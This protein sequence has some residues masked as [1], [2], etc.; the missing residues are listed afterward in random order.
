LRYAGDFYVPDINMLI[1]G[2]ITAL[3]V[4]ELFLAGK[5]PAAL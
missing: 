4:G 3:S 2:S 5:I 1:L